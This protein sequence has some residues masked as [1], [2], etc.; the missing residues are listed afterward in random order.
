MLSKRNVSNAFTTSLKKKKK[1]CGYCH[2]ARLRGGASGGQGLGESEIGLF[3]D[4]NH[5]PF[6]SQLLENS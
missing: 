2:A 6:F 3:G 5:R 1:D 4:L